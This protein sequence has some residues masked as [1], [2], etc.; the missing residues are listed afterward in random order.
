[1][2][3]PIA[4]RGAAL[5]CGGAICVLLAQACCAQPNSAALAAPRLGASAQN[6]AAP[7]PQPSE[8]AAQPAQISLK[9]GKLTVKAEN[10]DLSQILEDVAAI[11]G[12]AIKGL[13][14]GPRIFG[15]YGPASSR[16]V[17]VDLLV[18]SGYNFIMVGGNAGAPPRELVLTP[19]AEIGPS[20]SA[21]PAAASSESDQTEPDSSAEV[22]LGPGAIPHP[23]PAD[24]RDETTRRQQNLQ[25]LQQMHAKQQ[26]PPQ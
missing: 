1:M 15:D 16:E 4:K 12:M 24:A 14:Q 23:A 5:S 26:T 17:L 10:S 3:S 20:S 22:Q 13:G 18:G 8:T 21:P 2:F 19:S 25:R 6:G 7:Q 9:D 11:S